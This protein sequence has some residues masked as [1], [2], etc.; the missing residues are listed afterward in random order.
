MKIYLTLFCLICGGA[1]AGASTNTAADVQDKPVRLYVTSDTLSTDTNLLDV[2]IDNAGGWDDEYVSY[3]YDYQW[4]DGGG[5]NGSAQFVQQSDDGDSDGFLWG[6][7]NG[8]SS[9]MT[10]TA[11]GSGTEIDT[12]Y[13]GSIFTNAIGLPLLTS[14]HCVVNDSQTPPPRFVDDGDGNWASYQDYEEYVRYSQT[15]WRLQTGGRAGG[16]A[17]SS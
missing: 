13:A 1:L 10:W 7:T 5:G 15:R 12:Y 9:V 14:E 16:S 11:N 17:C 8:I 4:Q 3:Q 6:A 2:G